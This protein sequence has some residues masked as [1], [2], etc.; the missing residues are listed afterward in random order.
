MYDICVKYEE[1]ATWAA[2]N[3]TYTIVC[4]GLL[5]AIINSGFLEPRILC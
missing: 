5:I 4:N 1:S 2:I 3:V